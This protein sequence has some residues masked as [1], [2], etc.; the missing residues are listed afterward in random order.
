[1]LQ[2]VDGGMAQRR[3]VQERQVPHVQV[4]RPQRER[5]QGIREDA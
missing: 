2:G 4:H 3:L 5:D 1:M